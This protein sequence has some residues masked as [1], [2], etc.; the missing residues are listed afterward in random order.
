MVRKEM[1]KTANSN[2]NKELP[3]LEVRVSLGK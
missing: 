1:N 2:Q 3:P